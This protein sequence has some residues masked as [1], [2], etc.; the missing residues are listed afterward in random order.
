MAQRVKDIERIGT[1]LIITYNDCT[2]EEIDLCVECP[3]SPIED[4]PGKWPDPVITPDTRCRIALKLGEFAALRLN[5]FLSGLNLSSAGANAFEPYVALKLA[6]YGWPID[7]FDELRG[8][9]SDLFAAGGGAGLGSAAKSEYD[10]SVSANT[11]AVQQHLYCVLDDT[12]V[13]EEAQRTAWRTRLASD[14]TEDFETCLALFLDVWP[15]S[16]LRQ[17]AFEYSTTTDTVDCAL[18]DCDPNEV[19]CTPGTI[20]QT[21]FNAND[22]V[23]STALLTYGASHLPV[24]SFHVG[25]VNLTLPSEYCI[26]AV[27]ISHAGQSGSAWRKIR[28]LIDGINMGVQSSRYHTSC[29]TNNATNNVWIISPPRAGT[30]LTFLGEEQSANVTG[31]PNAPHVIHCVRVDHG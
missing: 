15:L 23:W 13:F 25:E 21:S 19:G 20:V 14:V 4:D 28:L 10:A 3:Q 16:Q 22:N 6:E 24:R 9:C 18:M 27:A 17:L 1:K 31:N 5:N 26:T 29:T 12:G 8:F 11:F 7:L 30:V 2:Q